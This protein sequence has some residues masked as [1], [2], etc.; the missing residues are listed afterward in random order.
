MV[1]A[2]YSLAMTTAV[3]LWSLGCWV[4]AAICAFV[5]GALAFKREARC[6]RKRASVRQ[7][8]SPAA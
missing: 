4:P 6:L 7:K 5:A 1:L 8:M 2:V 3:G